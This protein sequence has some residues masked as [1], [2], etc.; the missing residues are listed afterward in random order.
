MNRVASK[1]CAIVLFLSLLVAACSQDSSGS[2]AAGEPNP[3][4]ATELVVFAASSLTAA[5]QEIGATFEAEHEGVTVMFNTGPS[6]GLAAQIQSEGTADIFASASGAWMDAVEEDPGVTDRTDFVK[7]RLI[8]VT[9]Q[10][11]AAGIRSL[12][13]I[14]QPGVQLVLA[15]EGVPVGDYARELF[16]NAGI[17]NAALANVVSNEE[18]AASVVVKVGA[19]E[20]DAAVVYESDVSAA[21]GNELNAIEIPHDVNVIATYP[22]AVVSGSENPELAAAFVEAVIGAEGQAS[23]QRYG[24]QPIP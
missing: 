19:G 21:T 23:L 7:N 2:S 6:D 20:A 11:N 17:A 22:I 4:T 15:A 14:A 13:D 10:D 1:V 24:L 3:A 9:P 8:L 18:D 5:F 12:D 16:N